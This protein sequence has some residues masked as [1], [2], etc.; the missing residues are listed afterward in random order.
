MPTSPAA[1]SSV[2]S[3]RAAS[4][5]PPG[6]APDERT[7]TAT[8]KA[9]RNHGTSGGRATGAPAGAEPDCGDEVRR[10]SPTARVASSGASIATRVSFTTTA[11]ARASS[12]CVEAVATT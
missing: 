3:S 7:T 12:P 1:T 9:L 2:S 4:S 6:T 10:R 5:T 8:P 11:V